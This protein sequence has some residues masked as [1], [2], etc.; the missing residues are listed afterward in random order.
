MWTLGRFRLS[1]TRSA[2]PVGPSLP[3]DFRAVLAVAPEVRTAAQKDLLLAYFRVMDAD[4]QAK[5]DA[6]NASQAPLPADARLQELQASSSSP[7]SRS[8]PTRRSWP[9]AATSR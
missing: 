8:S 2:Q 3:E 5:T 7:A 1:A 9:C 6:L 4:L